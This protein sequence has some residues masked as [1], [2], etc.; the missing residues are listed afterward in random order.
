MKGLII[1]QKE[2]GKYAFPVSVAEAIRVGSRTL[3]EVV[4]EHTVYVANNGMED[5]DGSE[6]NPVNSLEKALE[7]CEYIP[8]DHVS[9]VL[10]EG[11]YRVSNT[12]L[13][14]S[15]KNLSFKAEGKVIISGAKIVSFE[16]QGN[17]LY[18][19][20]EKGHTPSTI[21]V[22]GV[23]RF[24]AST[25]RPSLL[26]SYQGCVMPSGVGNYTGD[27]GILYTYFPMSSHD[28]QTL[29]ED[30]K[31]KHAWMTIFVNW[32]SMKYRI[33][34]VDSV[35][36]RIE[37]R[38]YQN[39]SGDGNLTPSAGSRLIIENLD[40]ALD[41]NNGKPT[42]VESSFY[43]DNEGYI[44]YMPKNGENVSRI[45][46]PVIDNLFE[47]RSPAS[48][49]GFTFSQTIYNFF[50]VGYAC[51]DTQ[52]AYGIV[53]SIQC[54]GRNIEFKRCEFT[55]FEQTPIGFMN[56]SSNSLIDTCHFHHCGCTSVRIGELDKDSESVPYR[57]SV[58]NCLIEW[59]GELLQQSS[60]L[61]LTFANDC[62]IEHCDVS[63][64]FYTGITTGHVWTAQT[65]DTAFK[66]CKVRYNKIHHMNGFNMSDFGGFYNLGA[67]QGLQLI[68][69]EIS[70]IC[71][72]HGFGIY[73]DEGTKSA[74]VRNN[75]VY[76]VM[77]GI[78]F[79]YTWYNLVEN[80]IFAKIKNVVLTLN[81]KNENDE[82]TKNIFYMKNESYYSTAGALQNSVEIKQNLWYN[83]NVLLNPSIDKSPVVANPHFAN[84]ENNNYTITDRSN[85]DLI[86]FIPITSRAG[87]IAQELQVKLTESKESDVKFEAAYKSSM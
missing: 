51:S 28:I 63:K 21:Y 1:Q 78:H 31:Y 14:E 18:K 55:N 32:T 22:N 48:F 74:I 43:Y 53:P 41:I 27:D 9:I 82:I 58:V 3:K 29:L 83:P 77:G 33:L 42:L 39:P 50:D 69:N 17:R 75:T 4:S 20:V 40:A 65:P 37:F 12:I 23:K 10:K 49:D 85:T 81:S 60:G 80:N 34:K 30:E 44:Y 7:L 38:V 25:P 61:V 5:G 67:T 13:I 56:G 59:M 84:P 54:F 79:H 86:G 24:V 11:I 72:N 64:S 19:S 45:E 76:V 87:I 16:M 70:W 57:C 15:D 26:E 6:I 8:S 35:N 68:G 66:N 62:R 73:L 71:G 46:V 2:K 52:S 47:I 36:N